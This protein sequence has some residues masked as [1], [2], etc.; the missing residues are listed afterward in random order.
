[1]EEF[2]SLLFL[3]KPLVTMINAFEIWKPKCH[4]LDIFIT[5]CVYVKV[6]HL[7]FSLC[8]IDFLLLFFSKIAM[9]LDWKF[10]AKSQTDILIEK[11][12]SLHF[13][14]LWLNQS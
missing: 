5:V 1:M 8:D 4:Y 2:Q 3:E 11:Y 13:Y 10:C 6:F 9:H 12:D 14:L 7:L